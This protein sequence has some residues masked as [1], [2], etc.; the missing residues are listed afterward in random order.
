MQLALANIDD[1]VGNIY[2][3]NY[4]TINIHVYQWINFNF[5]LINFLSFSNFFFQILLE[6]EEDNKWS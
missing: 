1:N 6:L 4:N 3:A 5:G 2:I